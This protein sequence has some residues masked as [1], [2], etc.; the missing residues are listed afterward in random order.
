MDELTINLIVIAV[1]GAA[2]AGLFIFLAARKRQRLA[3]FE[4]AAN[5]RGWR[6]RRIEGALESGVSVEGGASGMPWT[7]EAKSTASDTSAGPG[8]SEVSLST[9]WRGRLAM[10]AERAVVAGPVP[11]GMD[12]RALLDGPMAAMALA[13]L[14]GRREAAW[15]DRLRPVDVPGMDSLF[16]L[17]EDAADARRLFVADAIRAL[18]ALPMHL[19]PVVKLR[20]EYL[21]LSLDGQRLDSAEDMAALVAL[22]EALTHAWN[23]P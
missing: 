23:A 7:L 8:S 1:T 15:A 10:P 5:A 22:G 9:R 3:D 12:V 6:V 11:A 17:A 4:A 20:T 16:C 19:R 18:A 14:L 13:K 21:E 2:I